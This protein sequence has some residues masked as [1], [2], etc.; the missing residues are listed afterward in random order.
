MKLYRVLQ[1]R[2][3]AMDLSGTGAFRWGGR[4]NSKGVYMLYTSENSSLAL[5]ESLVHF[6]EGET[7]PQL[8]TIELEIPDNAPVYMLPDS[9]YNKDWLKLSLLENQKQGDHWMEEKKYLAVRVRSAINPDEYNYLLNPV[10]PRYHNLVKIISVKK[11][12]VDE[13]LV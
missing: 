7:P 8:Y 2:N 6:D 1:D 12:K 13:R 5:L 10:F 4:W 9:E 3:R 11:I